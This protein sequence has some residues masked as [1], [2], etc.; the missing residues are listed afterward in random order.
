MKE[1][2]NVNGS[3]GMRVGVVWKLEGG[4]GRVSKSGQELTYFFFL[5]FCARGDRVDNEKKVE[6]FVKAR[7]PRRCLFGHFPAGVR[8]KVPLLGLR[9]I[10]WDTKAIAVHVADTILCPSISL[11]RRQ[12]EPLQCLLIVLRNASTKLI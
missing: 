10:S 6:N 5:H 9:L 7:E 4:E 1:R 12:Q 3:V 11:T 8:F 2:W